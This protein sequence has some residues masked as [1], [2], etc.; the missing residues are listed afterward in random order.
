MPRKKEPTDKST[1]KST[2]KPTGEPA[3]VTEVPRE[4]KP[5]NC[6]CH[7]EKPK[8]KSG[9]SALPGKEA[10]PSAAQIAA[11]ERFKVRVA[12]AKKIHAEHPDW[13]MHKCMKLAVSP[14][15]SSEDGGAQKE[16]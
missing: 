13:T 3:K 16:E 1:D 6:N 11:R 14:Q 9:K 12:E 2:G 10:Q 8:R 7:M 15:F 5:C 4:E